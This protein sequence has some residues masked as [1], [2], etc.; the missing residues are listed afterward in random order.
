MMDSM[1]IASV[2]HIILG[3]TSFQLLLFTVISSKYIFKYQQ[4]L[5]AKMFLM[6]FYLSQTILCICSITKIETKA[7]MT[8]DMYLIW[9]FA[10]MNHGSSGLMLGNYCYYKYYLQMSDDKLWKRLKIIIPLIYLITIMV[11]LYEHF[12][13]WTNGGVLIYCIAGLFHIITIIMFFKVYK[14]FKNVQY[15]YQH[16]YKI[17]YFIFAASI[18]LFYG[19]LGVCPSLNVHDVH[20]F[21]NR[22]PIAISYGY[23][24][25]FVHFNT[26]IQLKYYNQQQCVDDDKEMIIKV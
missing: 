21:I 4:I 24:G 5:K 20:E 6:Y 18:I 22:I 25:L 7:E 19:S 11:V 8:S 23:I 16:I 1:N 3:F 15:K 10:F 13:M 12:M 2:G 17:S 14:R 9:R 26:E